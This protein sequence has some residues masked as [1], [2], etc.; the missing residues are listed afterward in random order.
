MLIREEH[1]DSEQEAYEEL[2][3]YALARSDPSFIHQ[4]VVDAF[5]VQQA[6]EC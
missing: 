2:C 6:D 5:A 3:C 4:H 1:M